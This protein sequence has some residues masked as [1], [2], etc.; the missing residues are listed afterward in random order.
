[1]TADIITF[2]DARIAAEIIRRLLRKPKTHADAAREQRARQL[3]RSALDA[4]WG[5]P[6]PGED[7]RIAKLRALL[8]TARPEKPPTA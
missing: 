5:Q 8:A 3:V 6:V 1:M 4:A 2:D 7:L